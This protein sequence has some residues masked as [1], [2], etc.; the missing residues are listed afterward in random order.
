MWWLILCVT[1][2]GQGAQVKHHFWVCL[3]GCFQLR[4]A[5]ESVDSVDCPPHCGSAS[6][7][8]LG[9]RWR[10]PHPAPF[11][12]PHCL[13]WDISSH[14]LLPLDKDLHHWLDW[15]SGLW[16]WAELHLWPS[17]VSS[18]QTVELFILQNFVSHFLIKSV[19]IYLYLYISI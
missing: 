15:F 2:I 8:M 1:R 4:L 5:F 6:S 17:W 10:N 7:S 3:W 19:F 14:F 12:L 18:L 16:T 9:H 11:S 13:S